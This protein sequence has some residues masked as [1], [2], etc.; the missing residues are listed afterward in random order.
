MRT[1]FE[2]TFNSWGI[3]RVAF[4]LAK[5]LPPGLQQV[6][7]PGTAELQVF[8]VIGRHDHILHQ[9][10]EL[11]AE[12]KQ[13]VIIQYVLESSRTPN[14]EKWHDI[15]DKAKFVWSYY[16]LSKYIPPERFYHQPLACDP[17]NFFVANVDKKYLVGANGN[18]HARECVTEVRLAAWLHGKG[19]VAHVG[20][21]I[22][23]DPNVDY[24]SN[25][26]D[27]EL[28]QVYNAC[29]WWAALRR[30]DGFEM[31]A[32][33]ALMCGVTPIMFDTPNFRQWFDG[34]AAFVPESESDKLTDHIRA[35]FARPPV[36]LTNTQIEDIRQRFNWPR[37]IKG[38]WDRCMS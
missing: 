35:V 16:D 10:Q 28:R 6:S 5:H 26:S 3:G 12:G 38:F 25:I 34:L 24:Y 18:D 32:V 33:E 8:H 14:P 13:Y 20:L 37:I 19:K 21:P 27:D 30:K 31:P 2:V 1:Y 23:A 15:W 4:Q 29:T 36:P 17:D 9:T 7:D 11:L 22:T